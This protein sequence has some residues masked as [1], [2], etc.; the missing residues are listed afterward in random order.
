MDY[1]ETQNSGYQTLESRREKGNGEDQTIETDCSQK[2]GRTCGVP[3]Q[4]RM[5]I[6]N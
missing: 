4:S 3:Q 2:G 5:T 1:I 6:D